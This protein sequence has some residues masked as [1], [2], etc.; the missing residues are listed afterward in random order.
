VGSNGIGTGWCMW[1]GL[2]VDQATEPFKQGTTLL[3]YGYRPGGLVLCLL[4]P[5]KAVSRRCAP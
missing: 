4:S 3:H 5:P 1:Y 2:V